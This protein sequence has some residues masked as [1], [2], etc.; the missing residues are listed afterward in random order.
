MDSYLLRFE[1]F[2]TSQNWDK[3]I[4]ATNLSAL[5]KGKALEVCSRLTHEQALDYDTL[6]LA[7]LKRFDMTEYAFRKR[8][9][10]C[11][12]EHGET[13]SQFSIRM[14]NY[15]TR[16][17]E[18]AKVDRTYEGL[19]DLLLRNQILQSCGRDLVLF[20]REHTP[21]NIED[22]AKLAD[23]F[24]DA[25]G[26]YSRNIRQLPRTNAKVRVPNSGNQINHPNTFAARQNASQRRCYK[27]NSP[28]HLSIQCKARPPV[29]RA[30]AVSDT[31]GLRETRQDHKQG[32]WRG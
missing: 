13:F 16:W 21:E 7:L 23:I 2:A 26:N 32:R 31:E 20:L 12:P 17:I 28:D 19:L 11:V 8:F 18:L 14:N 30:M 27:C 6:K 29:P 9:Y 22:L 25:R 24:L 3:G 10:S 4:W 15:L 1:R 5:L